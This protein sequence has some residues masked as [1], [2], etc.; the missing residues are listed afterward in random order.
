M[1]Y[2]LIGELV[3][4]EPGTAVIDCNGVGY[5]LTISSVTLGKLTANADKSKVKLFTYMSVREDAVE[6]FGFYEYD[7]LT[8]FKMLI[9]VSG[10]GPKAAMAVLSVLSPD[11]LAMAV[12]AGDSKLISSA[13]GVGAK[14]AARI[15][16]E[17]KDKITKEI[18]VS[19]SQ[20]VGAVSV[21]DIEDN[22][23]KLSDVMNT[24]TVLGYTK[25]EASYALKDIDIAALDTESIIRA[26]LKK[27]MK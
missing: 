10:V 26:A 2:H 11:K 19:S 15:V 24:L 21:S 9:T 14:T 6:L 25:A 16:L 12:S 17:L 20:G 23:S 5:K 7:E 1:I 18:G 27:L 4:A 3:L 13:Q 8:A 22:G